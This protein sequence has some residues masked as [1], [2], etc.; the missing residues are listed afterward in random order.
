[1]RSLNRSRPHTTAA[2]RAGRRP[3]WSNDMPARRPSPQ[4]L[5]EAV[6]A[7]YIHDISQRR[8]IVRTSVAEDPTLHTTPADASYGSGPEC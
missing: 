7:S 8:R 4:R 3:A 1:M 2:N 5:A 6:T